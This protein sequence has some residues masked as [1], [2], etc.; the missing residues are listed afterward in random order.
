MDL[1]KILLSMKSFLTKYCIV[2]LME[3][4]DQELIIFND[5]GDAKIGIDHVFCRRGLFDFRIYG[6]TG[7]VFDTTW[8]PN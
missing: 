5:S 4:F 6:P 1:W 2:I 8:N 3:P 7:K